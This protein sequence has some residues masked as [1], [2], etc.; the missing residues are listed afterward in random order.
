M[1]DPLGNNIWGQ[2]DD[3]KKKTVFRQPSVLEHFR[4]YISLRGGTGQI[5]GGFHLAKNANQSLV[6]CTLW[7][8][9]V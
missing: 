5:R 4:D 7:M 1:N 3:K 2:T 9:V 6:L 8:I